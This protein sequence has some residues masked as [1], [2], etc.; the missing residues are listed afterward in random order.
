MRRWQLR[1][2]LSCIPPPAPSQLSWCSSLQ[3]CLAQHPVH[4][5]LYLIPSARN[6]GGQAHPS[7]TG[8]PRV[9]FNLQLFSWGRHNWLSGTETTEAHSTSLDAYK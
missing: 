4:Y 7:S 8:T 2:L 1:L 5:G 9:G 6:M 3:H